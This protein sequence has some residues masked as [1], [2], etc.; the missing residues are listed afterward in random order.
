M[1]RVLALLFA[2]GLGALLLGM[3][4]GGGPLAAAFVIVAG[5]LLAVVVVGIYVGA[6]R[7]KGWE[8]PPWRDT[9]RDDR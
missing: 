8:W 2:I 1:G 5:I 6:W 3:I 4:I 7:T 9:G